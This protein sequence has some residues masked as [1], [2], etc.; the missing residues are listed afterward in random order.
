MPESEMRA[1]LA[2]AGLQVDE[3]HRIFVLPGHGGFQFLPTR[4]L[5]AVEA[6]LSRIPLANRISKNQIYVCRR[7]QSATL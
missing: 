4:W 7:T 2:A 5:V 6:F 3:I 1:V